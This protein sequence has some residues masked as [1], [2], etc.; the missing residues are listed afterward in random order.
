ME[1]SMFS[2]LEFPQKNMIW[3]PY[4]VFEVEY[5]WNGWV[6]KDRVNAIKSNMIELTFIPIDFAFSSC[7][8]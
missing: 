7:L 5:L 6:K 4:V 8:S 3:G 1:S 2:T